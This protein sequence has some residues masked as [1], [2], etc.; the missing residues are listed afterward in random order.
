[1]TF[2]DF[3]QPDEFDVITR[4]V[5]MPSAWQAMWTEAEE[6]LH[7]AHPEGFDVLDIGRVAFDS[8]PES[9]REAALDCLFYNYW[10]ARISD[11]AELE[12]YEREKHARAEIRYLLGRFQD[13]AESQQPVPYALLADIAR[14]SL[15]LMGT[16]S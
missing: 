16:A 3:E 9:E 5:P 14:L 10:A 13:L 12:R 6:M 8:L 4:E 11:E 1:M 2:D 7:A 15:P